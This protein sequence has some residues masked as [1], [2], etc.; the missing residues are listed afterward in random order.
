MV[1]PEAN[2]LSIMLYP[3]TKEGMFGRYF[4]GKSNIDLNNSFVVLELDGLS[5]KGN[6]RSVALFILMIQ[7]NQVMYL[8]GNKRQIKQVI[9]DEAWQLLGKG[10]AGEFIEKGYRVARKYGGSYMTITQKISD[11]SN[12]EVPRRPL[13]PTPI[14]KSIYARM[15]ANLRGWIIAMGRWIF[16]GRWKPSKGSIASWRLNLRMEW[17]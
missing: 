9:I 12:S 1:I 14:L 10:R 11:Y 5:D 17:P 6:L 16:C 8:S 2:N 15:R 7:I 3:Y 13:M 4:E